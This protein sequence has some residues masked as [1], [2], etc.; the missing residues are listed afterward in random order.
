MLQR[1]LAYVS[2]HSAIAMTLS[3]GTA[4]TDSQ[5]IEEYETEERQKL[6]TERLNNPENY[7]DN[8]LLYHYMRLAQLAK[9]ICFGEYEDIFNN[10]MILAILVAGVLV[11]IQTYPGL[12][13]NP[14]VSVLEY[15]VLTLFLLEAFLKI[16]AEGFRPL[17]YFIGKDGHWNTFDFF[18]IILCLP[19]MT[20][21]FQGKSQI[22]RIVTR[23]SRLVRASKIVRQIPALHVIIMGLV[24]GLKSIMYIAI[25]LVLVFYFFAVIGVILFRDNDP[26]N[27]RS[28]PIAIYCLFRSCTL[29]GW[30]DVFKVNAYG[31]KYYNSGIYISEDEVDSLAWSK[32]PHY[33]RCEKAQSQ[34]VVATIFW[35]TF[36]VISALVM[37]ALFVGCITMSM[38]ESLNAMKQEVEE[39]NRKFRLLKQKQEIDA[40]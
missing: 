15:G 39:A 23:L 40:L 27:F 4:K 38:Q 16:L 3:Q 17:L 7:K 10:I 11:G 24:G 29:D 14:I 30:G 18:V 32:I 9:L 28:V 2:Q 35:I 31:C 20:D 6:E 13:G 25:L 12:D 26:F 34:P 19:F 1:G 36:I 22:I 21:L 33:Y 5:I 8:F 37:L